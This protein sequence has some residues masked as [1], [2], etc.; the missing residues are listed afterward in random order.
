MCV[1][2]S[3]GG[4]SDLIGESGGVV[5]DEMKVCLEQVQVTIMYIL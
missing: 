2:L 1:F 3:E 4:C 5:G